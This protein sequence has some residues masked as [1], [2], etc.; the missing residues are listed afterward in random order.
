MLA[1]GAIPGVEY[2]LDV[3]DLGVDSKE[4]RAQRVEKRRQASG[5]AID[6]P[7]RTGRKRRRA[8]EVSDQLTQEHLARE[9]VQERPGG[10]STALYGGARTLTATEVV[11]AE[12]NL[13]ENPLSRRLYAQK[14]LSAEQ[15]AD[16]RLVGQLELEM[17]KREKLPWYK[18]RRRP[19]RVDWSKRKSHHLSK[20][21]GH[22][23]TV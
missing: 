21:R 14:L 16:A 20:P 13:R 4:R 22:A 17:Q 1:A 8:A 9:A 15:A 3:L 12:Q 2:H 10:G 19:R 7:V 18:R 11:A 23:F 5:S 6:G